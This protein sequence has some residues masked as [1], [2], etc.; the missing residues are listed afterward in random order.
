MSQLSKYDQTLSDIAKEGIRTQ[1]QKYNIA[2]QNNDTQGMAR[3]NENAN[4]IRRIYGG[5]T[6]GEDGS[7]FNPIFSTGGK[8]PEYTSR[9]D[10]DINNAKKR[11]INKTPFYYDPQKDPRYLLYQEIYTRMGN[12]AYDR[13]LSQNAIK[14]GGIV[15]TNATTSAMLAK[16]KYNSELAKIATDLYNDAYNEYKDDIRYEYDKMDMLRSLEQSDYSKHKDLVDDFNETS[17]LGYD[18]Y[19]DSID[20]TIDMLENER[21]NKKLEDEKQNNEN[22]LEYDYAKLNAQNAKWKEQAKTDKLNTL[23]RLI[24]SVYNKSNI[25]VNIQRIL[26]LM[27]Y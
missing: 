8:K 15:N 12:D 3:A 1:K 9:Y 7:E 10:N 11:I 24:Q 19:R 23:A 20:D 27:D 17:K 21:L 25:G 14:T 13:A 18:K 26:D 5:Y 16:N 4:N 6:G 2:K 22:Q